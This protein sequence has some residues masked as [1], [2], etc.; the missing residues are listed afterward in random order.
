MNIITERK[1]TNQAREKLPKKDFVFPK[2]RRYPVEDK[3][4]AR[5]ALAR[6]SQH[7]TT[8]EKA[9]VRATVH[10]KYPGIGEC[11]V[12]PLGA[13]ELA[14]L[15]EAQFS[16]KIKEK[17]GSR[18]VTVNAADRDDALTKCVRLTGKRPD[19]IALI[20]DEPGKGHVFGGPES[21]FGSHKAPSRYEPDALG[22]LTMK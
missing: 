3:S 4:H 9:K 18:S 2:E 1:L 11:K 20:G 10:R 15:N 13:A 16:C 19:D 22:P 8:A 21:H 7:G 12:P 14:E 6:V 17:Y 5:N